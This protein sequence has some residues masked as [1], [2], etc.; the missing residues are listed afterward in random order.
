MSLLG[1]INNSAAALANTQTQIGVVSNNIGNSNSPNF[2][3]RQANLIESNPASGGTDQVQITRAVNT[4]LQQELLQQSTLSSNQTFTNNIYTQLEQ[5]DGS[6]SGTPSLTAATQGFTTAFQALE[7]DPG[8]VPSQQGVIQ[9]GQTLAQTVQTIAG[10]VQ[11]IFTQVGQQAESDVNTLNTSLATIASLNS[12]IAAAAGTGQSTA[13]LGDTLDATIQTVANLVPIRVSFADNGTAQLTT[14]SGIDLVSGTTPSSFGFDSATDTIF[15]AG[16]PSEAS[17][18]GGF[19]GGQIG[20]EISTLD[21]SAAGVASQNPADAPLQK[22]LVQLNGFA[23]QFFA[24]TPPGPATAF[25]AAYNNATPTNPGELPADF[26]TIPNFGAAPSTD[27]FNFQVNPAL[28]NGTATVKQ[29]SVPAVVSQLIATNN[30]FAAGG[31][32]TTNS[33][34]T[35]ITEAIASNQTQRAQL[36]Q[37]NQQSS[38]AALTTTQATYQNAT[39]VNVNTELTQ[40]IVLQNTYG[41]SAKV[42][43]VVQ[44]LFTALEG[45]IPAT[46]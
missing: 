9:A 1:I 23:D 15:A 41:A 34:Y 5:L 21:T 33:T 6:A 7:A 4:T 37:T 12:Q 42:I 26:F 44:S 31:V 27:A 30:N 35:G 3:A 16:D 32:S 19:A 20:A 13:A 40:L 22:I 39:G 18:N 36:A 45:A 10:G 11:A 8:S 24:P 43:S 25:Q 29:A 14:P 46:A 2:V 38:S 28:L 17:L